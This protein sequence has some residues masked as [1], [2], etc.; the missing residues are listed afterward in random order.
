[1]SLDYLNGT[2]FEIEQNSEMYHFNSDTELLGRFIRIRRKDTVLDVGCNNGALMMYASLYKPAGL[3]GID[4][5][6]EATALAGKNLSR[7]NIAHNMITGK[8]QD[9]KDIHFDVIVCN[10]PYFNTENDS[11]LSENEYKKAARHE[12]YLPLDQLFESADRLLKDQGRFFLVHR[13]SR[14]NDIMLYIRQHDMK[15]SRLA[16][17]Y[18][19]QGKNAKSILLEIRKGK[20]PVPVAEPPIYLDDRSTFPKTGIR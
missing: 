20:C 19:S 8:V 10:P 9:L 14:I 3:Y 6:E 1:M 7:Y 16:L 2:D 15:V 4:L 11:L 5:F 17:A 12:Q 13:A 18:E